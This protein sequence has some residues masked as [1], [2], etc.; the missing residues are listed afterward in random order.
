MSP[1][2]KKELDPKI[3]ARLEPVV[4]ELF[5]SNDFHQV[6][7]RLIAKKTGIGLN[8]IYMNFESKEKLLFSFI[9]EWI[10]QL[11]GRVAEHLQGIEDSKEKIRKTIWV[12]LNYYETNPEVANIVL[13]TVPFKTWMADETFEQKDSSTRIIGLFREGQEKGVLDPNIPAEVMFDF[14]YG[15]IHR[16]VYIWLYL[17]RKESLVS[18]TNLYC[19]MIWRAFSRPGTEIAPK[20]RD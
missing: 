14:F 19:E 3:K 5:S 15:V 7:M 8:T 9:N 13:L 17:N 1:E 16:V 12:I 20:T 4:K 2:T 10:L 11:D 18:N 6:N